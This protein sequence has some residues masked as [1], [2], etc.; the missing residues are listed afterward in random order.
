[1]DIID[2]LGFDT[3][4]ELGR[5]L[6]GPLLGILLI[7]VLASLALR[8]G[9]AA[10]RRSVE[11]VKRGQPAWIQRLEDRPGTDDP[12]LQVRRERRTTAL[13]ALAT[14]V[15]TVVVWT[16]AV[17]MILDQFGI[18]LAPV[19]ASAGIVGVALGFGAQDLVKDFL[20]GVF[21]L[22]E[23]QYG[24][25]DTVT[26]GEASGVVE[27]VT[28]RS[29]RIRDVNGTL[30][31]IPN[32][33]IR[34]VGNQSQGWARSLLD[35]DVAYDTDLASASEAILAIATSMSHEEPWDMLFLEEPEMWGVERLGP[36]SVSLRLVIKVL[37]G[38]QWRISRELR[39]RI[40]DEFDRLGIE[41]PFQQRTLWI[42]EQGAPESLD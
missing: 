30:W 5:R 4:G 7:L 19:I 12:I 34:R 39:R 41:I 15:L 23:D 8:I 13:A 29:T 27:G 35:V 2:L 28:L 1:V 38:E 24:L 10:I 36:D 6:I 3:W 33:E 26:V 18:A 11:R 22:A 37:P 25:G 21:I 16:I 40:K 31:H 42:R 17:M 20:S 14:S 9:R 32:G